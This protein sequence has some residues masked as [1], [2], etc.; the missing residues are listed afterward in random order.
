MENPCYI[1]FLFL[2]LIVLPQKRRIPQYKIKHCGF[3]VPGHGRDEALPVG[4]QGIGMH[5]MRLA[6]QRQPGVI[7]SESVAHPQVHLMVHKPERNLGYLA[8]KFF[9]F[10]A[11][12]LPDIAKH[13]LADI[14]Y[15]LDAL[16]LPDHLQ[17]QGA[18]LAVTDNQEVAAATGRVKET[19]FGELQVKL[20]E[21]IVALGAVL[22]RF[23]GLKLLLQFVEEERFDELQDVLFA[24]VVRTEVAALFLVHHALKQ[25]AENGR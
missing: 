23:D 25:A 5:N 11:V 13:E 8:G 20:I 10:Y 12:K 17:F 2:G 19:E 22:V 24:G 18:E 7:L 6:L 1:L 14:G 3:L 4:T 9:Y 15:H 16:Q 21:G